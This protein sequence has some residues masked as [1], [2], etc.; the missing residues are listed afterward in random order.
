M[1]IQQKIDLHWEQIL[2]TIKDKLSYEECDKIE[3]HVTNIEQLAKTAGN[4]IGYEF[5]KQEMLNDIEKTYA[6]CHSIDN[7]FFKTKF[8]L[9]LKKKREGAEK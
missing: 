1:E 7:K 3:G 6:S 9:I 8:E 5:G 2:N 4:E